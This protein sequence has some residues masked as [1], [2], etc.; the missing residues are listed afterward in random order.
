MAHS[1]PAPRGTFALSNKLILSFASICAL[2]ATI[3]GFIYFSVHSLELLDRRETFSALDEVGVLRAIEKDADLLQ[4]EVFR[5]LTE[6]SPTEKRTHSDI[7]ERIEK[8]N[9]AR[10]NHYASGSLNDEK[11]H[12]NEELREKRAH[13]FAL[14]QE[15]LAKEGKLPRPIFTTSEMAAQLLAYEEYQKSLGTLI[16][17]TEGEHREIVSNKSARIAE[18]KSIGD[19]LLGVAILVGT[20]AGFIL[21]RMIASLKRDKIRLEN[22]MAERE[23]AGTALRE[24]EERH[25][26]LL[27]RIPDAVYVICE[28]RIVFA[29]QAAQKLLAGNSD[30]PV[31]G[32]KLD[33][34]V[35][36]EDREKMAPRA[37]EIAARKVPVPAERRLLRLDGTVAEVETNSM[38]STFEGRPAIQVITR[39]IADRKSAAERLRAQEKQ[40]RIL[41]EDN[42]SP[43]WVYE[44]RSLKFLAVNRAAIVQYGYS[45]EEFL[46]LV[47]GDIQPNQAGPRFL[48][49]I[50][51][52]EAATEFSGLWRHRKKNGGIID[53]AIHSTPIDFDGKRARLVT[54]F[55]ITERVESE[56][57]IREREASLS[58]A[59]HVAGVGSWEYQFGPDGRIDDDKLFWSAEVYH[60]FGQKPEHFRPSTTSFFQAVHPADRLKVAHEFRQFESEGRRLSVDHRIVLPDGSERIV[61]IAAEVITQG[62]NKPSKVIGTI[63]DITDQVSKAEALKEAEQKYRT[64]FANA[65]EGIFQSSPQGKFL[66]VNPAAARIFGFSS[67]EEMKSERSDITRQSYVDPQ[68][69][70][71]FIRE[72]ER[73]GVVTGFECE[74]YR[75]DGSKV[76]ISENARAVRDAAGKTLYFEGTLQ[77]ISERKRSE[78]QLREQ[79]EL[80][81]LAHDAIMVRDMED[82]VEFWNRGAEA[83]Y[84]WT[85]EEVRGRKT[86]DFL[87]LSDTK[88]M[89]RARQTLLETGTWSGESQHL[90][91]SGGKVIVRGRWSLLRD[92]LG[93]P[94]SKLVINTDITAQK[95]IEEQFLRTQR[96]E[97][98]GTLASGIA[99]DLNNVLLPVLMAAPILRAETDPEER[100]KFLDIVEASAQRGASIVRQVVTFARGADGEHILLQPLYLLDEVSKIAT[101][102]FSEIDH[103]ADD[104]QRK[105][106]ESR[107]RPDAA[108]PDPAQPLHQRTRRD[109]QRRAHLH[110][111]PRT[112]TSTNTSRS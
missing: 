87:H 110:F 32:A 45:R 10:L 71:D 98:I 33:L 76:W 86:S 6:T 74:V 15:L 96:L 61:H 49:A 34:F 103:R 35:Q 27:E 62:E 81:H 108:P 11:R 21:F 101:P 97:S 50:N 26:I 58:L 72:I 111:P 14:T 5:S 51:K 47:I 48:T 57:K 89:E 17:Y 16:R 3:S 77:D 37:L 91:K 83:L 2:L 24:S 42:P 9:S 95:R 106:A 41:F 59:Q 112:S 46:S 102:N 90:T 109:A 23:K 67:P 88:P 82:R 39:D 28:E 105:F 8:K 65:S 79:A 18:T 99:H 22:E 36:P 44:L 12:L 93:R 80:L 4:A 92:E 20:W 1:D 31:V 29:N 107:G 52:T 94:K 73:E 40:Y 69:R 38:P 104:A 30:Q 63:M 100:S 55:D 60:L 56:R 78:E 68:R 25:R 43:M 70:T 7:I 66:V 75:K 84:G 54:A 53:V 19:V 85:A 64:I 13:F